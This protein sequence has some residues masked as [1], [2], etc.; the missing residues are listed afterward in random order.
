M[1]CKS[2][3]TCIWCSYHI[4]DENIIDFCPMCN[5]ERPKKYKCCKCNTNN[6]SNAIVCITCKSNRIEICQ[7]CT[8]QFENNIT[9]PMCNSSNQTTE[10]KLLKLKQEIETESLNKYKVEEKS[11]NYFINNYENR[12][13][14]LKCINNIIIT[15]VNSKDC[16]DLIVSYTYIGINIS[17]FEINM[18]NK[19]LKHLHDMLKMEIYQYRG[20]PDK[21][22]KYQRLL[23]TFLQPLIG[24]TVYVKLHQKYKNLEYSLFAYFWDELYQV[25][26]NPFISKSNNQFLI[27]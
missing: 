16:I 23:D 19:H 1:D 27:C 5:N 2:G 14:N 4:K 22:I 18:Y 6:K 24:D 20:L 8:F 15:F 11:I 13:D 26:D 3:W 10:F 25:N 7:F 17:L 9:C 12:N 21:Q